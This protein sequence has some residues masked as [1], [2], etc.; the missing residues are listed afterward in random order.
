MRNCMELEPLYPRVDV[1]NAS[2]VCMYWLSGNVKE[3]LTL[4]M[5]EVKEPSVRKIT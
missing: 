1:S 3:S 4:V 5:R 2:V